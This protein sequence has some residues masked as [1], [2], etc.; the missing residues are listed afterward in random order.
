MSSAKYRFMV[1]KGFVIN[2]DNSRFQ[3]ENDAEFSSNSFYFPIEAV[4]ISPPQED[5]AAETPELPSKSISLSISLPQWLVDLV[6]KEMEDLLI[7]SRSAIIAGALKEHF[8][9]VLKEW[10]QQQTEE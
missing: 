10:Y 7:D 9:G 5:K 6:D 4:G 3:L 8:V 1:P 2:I